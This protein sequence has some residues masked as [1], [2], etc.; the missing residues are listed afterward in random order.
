ME[1]GYIN[2]PENVFIDID[3]IKNYTD[4]QL[5]IITTGSQGETMSALTRMA[6]GDHKKVTITPNDLVIISANPIPGNEKSVS[7]VIDQLMK[8]GAE[9]V[10]S[11]LA[12]IHVSG[13]GCQEEQKLMLSLIKPKYFMPVHGEYRMLKEHKNLAIS[14][15]IPEDKIFILKNGESVELSKEGVKR[16]KN[17]Q[18]GDVYVDGSRIGS[19]GSVVL[20]DRK[21]MSKDGI[22]VAILNLDVAKKELLIHPNVTTRGFIL[23]NEN[24]DLILSISRRIESTV[25]KYFQANAK[26]NYVD[27]KNQIILDLNPYIIELTGRRPI[28]LPVVMEIK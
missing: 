26:Y 24:A 20:K 18:A 3:M 15:D 19:V 27:L 28:I 17:Y 1:L 13:H 22:L 11:A 8:I 23:V 14:C 16:G 25:K 21:L 10:Y 2:L 6:T 4:D 7:K 12:D 9:V 5:V